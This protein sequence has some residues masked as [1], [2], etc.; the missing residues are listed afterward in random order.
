MN[1]V[2]SQSSNSGCDG[3]SPCDAEVFDGLHDAGAEIHLPEP[4]HGHA[5]EQRIP[6]V[7]HPS[8]KSQA[9]VRSALRQRRQDSGHTGLH[10]I[11]RLVISAARQHERVLANRTLGHHH[12]GGEAALEFF[13]FLTQRG[14]ALPGFPHVRRRGV[15]QVIPAKL[16]GFPRFLRRFGLCAMS[17]IDS[18]SANAAISS[19]VQHRGRRRGHRRSPRGTAA[20]GLPHR[21]IRGFES[22]IRHCRRDGIANPIPPSPSPACHRCR[23]ERLRPFWIRNTLRRCDT[24]ALLPAS[25][26]SPAGSRRPPN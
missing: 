16:R 4:I 22:L 13:F 1:S 21:P 3:H 23:R 5:R 2:A 11:A 17:L 10:F 24:S 9:I 15:L 7:N 20:P 19:S 14:E 12:D 18:P 25:L 8:C 6:G 26:R